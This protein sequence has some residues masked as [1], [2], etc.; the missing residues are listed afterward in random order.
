MNLSGQSPTTEE[1][2][3]EIERFGKKCSW[4]VGNIS[5]KEDACTMEVVGSAIGYMKGK[6]AE[7]L[8]MVPK[9]GIPDMMDKIYERIKEEKEKI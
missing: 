3:N 1:W 8:G 4:D 6:R 9:T 7:K 2:V 5:W